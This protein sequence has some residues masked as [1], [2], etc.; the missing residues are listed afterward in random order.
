[1]T[2]H[3]GKREGAGR[4]SSPFLLKSEL[5]AFKDESERKAYMKTSTRQRVLLVLNA[6]KCDECGEIMDV[7]PDGWRICNDCS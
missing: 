6:Q 2:N 7:L 5:L 3:G 4:K 1:M